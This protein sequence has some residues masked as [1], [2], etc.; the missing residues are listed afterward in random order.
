MFNGRKKISTTFLALLILPLIAVSTYVSTV[1]RASDHDDGEYDGKGRNLN[2]TDL[3][4]F[5]ESNFETAGLDATQLVLIMNSNPRSLPRQQYFFSTTAVYDFHISRVGVSSPTVIDTA[6]TTNDNVI[7]R[8]QFGAPN[9]SNVQSITMTTIVDGVS[10][11]A[12]GT[13]LTTSLANGGSPTNNT[14]MV[15]SNSFSVFAGL[16]ADPFYFD[17]QSFFKWRANIG[18]NPALSTIFA[19]A[20]FAAGYNVNSI[21]VRL[22]IAF[23][24][25]SSQTVFDN[26]VTVSVP[27]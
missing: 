7:L 2:L 22:P 6:G 27:K 11:V 19:N 24:Q 25:T 16:R 23:L 13:A 18:S 4:V 20:N 3:Y 1:A 26:W 21:V 17:V 8:F 9:S 10:T 12:T 14:L 5:K 15:G